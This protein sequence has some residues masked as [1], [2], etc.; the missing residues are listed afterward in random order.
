VVVRKIGSHANTVRPICMSLCWHQ[1]RF[2]ISWPWVYFIPTY[3]LCCAA[4]YQTVVNELFGIFSWGWYGSSKKR[5][6]NL[7]TYCT[8]L[9][10]P[11]TNAENCR[12]PVLVSVPRLDQRDAK[13]VSALNLGIIQNK[14]ILQTLQA[15][16]FILFLYFHNNSS[17]EFLAKLRLGVRAGSIWSF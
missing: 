13:L 14:F 5:L 17:D 9:I 8:S 11:Q 16:K 7:N 4:L 12:R 1:Q 10:L 3:V 6:K 15:S 2:K